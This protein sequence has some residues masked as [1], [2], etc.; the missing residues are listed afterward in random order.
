MGG[1]HGGRSRVSGKEGLTAVRKRLQSYADR[2]VFRGLAEEPL[3]GSRYRFKFLWLTSAPFTLVYAPKSGSIVIRDLLPNLGP[4][5]AVRKGIR[6]FILSRTDG[7]LPEHRRIDVRCVNVACEVRRGLLSVKLVAKRR[8]HDYAVNRAV[9]LIH[10]IFV[11]L[12][13]YFPEYMWEN[14]DVPEE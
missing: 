5:T 4:R 9:N 13:T 6:A 14:F 2:G 3:R 12:H 10:E 7:A 1:R 8:D 11:Q